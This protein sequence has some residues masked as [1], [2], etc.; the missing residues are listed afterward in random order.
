[1]ADREYKLHPHD[2]I[3]NRMILWAI[4]DWIK[5]NHVTILR[6][7]LTPPVVWLVFLRDYDVAFALFIIAALTDAIDGSMA[8]I[9]NQITEWGELFD[10]VADKLLIG[11]VGLILIYRY[12][13]L[14]LIVTILVLEFVTILAAFYLKKKHPNFRPKAN[15]FGKTK[16]FLQV[17]GVALL[18]IFAQMPG[19]QVLSVGI[20]GIFTVSIFFTI[21][22]MYFAGI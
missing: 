11:S 7:I 5:P 16:M 12:L 17:V 3:V 14:F 21:L 10:P 19:N 1:M 15:V 4:P 9:R 18:L 6:F 20:S 2:F 13:H 22:S 8:R